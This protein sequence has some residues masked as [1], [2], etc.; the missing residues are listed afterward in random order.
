MLLDFR[1]RSKEFII[2]VPP[3]LRKGRRIRLAGMGEEGKGGGRQNSFLASSCKSRSDRDPRFG[4]KPVNLDLLLRT[5]FFMSLVGLAAG[6]VNQK[7]SLAFLQ[8]LR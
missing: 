2:N 4:A 1:K 3:R 5:G 7:T 8:L 6:S